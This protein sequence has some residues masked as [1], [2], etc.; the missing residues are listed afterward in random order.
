MYKTLSPEQIEHYQREGILSP[1]PALSSPEVSRYRSAFE[2]WEWRVGPKPDPIQSRQLHLYFRWAYDLATHPAI[3]D[4]VEDIL[5]P[6]ILVHS[7]TMFSKRPQDR[8]YVSW[9][10]DGYYWSLDT[11]QLTSAWVALTDSTVQ[12]GCMR[13]VPGSHKWGTLRHAE[14]SI[15]RNNLLAS[16]LEV[17]VDIEESQA[18]DISLKAGQMSIHHV[19]IVHGSNANRSDT[20]RIGFAIRYAAPLVKQAIAHHQVI[21][22]RGR[23]DYHHFELMREPPRANLEEGLTAHSE[24]IRWLRGFRLSDQSGG[25]S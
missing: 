17:A 19:N 2:E 10:Q 16:G 21:L 14:S 3:L 15:S 23:D 13:V 12:N 20:N 7:T 9:H 25:D 4:A 8:S 22:A 6:N 24:F 11:P 1:V 18:R 5:G